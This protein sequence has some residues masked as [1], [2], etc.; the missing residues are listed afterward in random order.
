M[1]APYFHDGSVDRLEDAVK[2]MAK[3]RLGKNI[4]AGQAGAI[5]AFP[6]SLTGRIPDDALQVPIVPLP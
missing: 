4:D 3:V 2:I 6:G 5:A 1:T